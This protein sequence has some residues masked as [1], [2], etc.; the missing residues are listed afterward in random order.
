M[1]DKFTISQLKER[2]SVRSFV[3]SPLPQPLRDSIKAMITMID[4]HEAG[5]HFEA[6][7]D[8]DDPFRGFT[9]S[10]GFFRNPKNY[11]AAVVDLSYPD[12]YDR[13]GFF[14]EQIVMNLVTMELGTCFV[15]GTFDSNHTGVHLR[16][17]RKILFL[18]LF[19]IEDKEVK[20]PVQ[21]FFTKLMKRNNISAE[22][23][24]V[25]SPQDY[26]EAEKAVPNLDECLMA[27]DCAPSSLNKR[28]AR[29][30]WRDNHIE[31]YLPDKK[32]D[33][34][35][36]DLGIAKFNVQ[37]VLPEDKTGIMMSIPGL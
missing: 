21:G 24:F 28:P 26:Q 1:I 8:N 25:G 17:D 36:I 9:R 34:Q 11:I 5:M 2:R 10:Y 13:A 6:F 4:T 27:L 19:G 22:K 15:G 12:P 32:D 18:I 33:K 23:F 29:L 30:R 37:A 3:D 14:A 20:R 16:A 35:L 31:V 7:F